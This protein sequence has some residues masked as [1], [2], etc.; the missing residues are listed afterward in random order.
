MKKQILTFLL[1]IL[2]I[3]GLRSQTINFEENT[4]HGLQGKFQGSLDSD[5]NVLISTGFTEF[6]VDSQAWSTE[7][8]SFSSGVATPLS[9]DDLIDVHSGFGLVGELGGTSGKD[10]VVVGSTSITDNFCPEGR[11]YISNSSGGYDVQ[12]IEGLHQSQGGLADF[13]GDGD[14]DV[15]TQG[16]NSSGQRIIIVYLNN[17]GNFVQGWVADDPGKANGS[18]AIGNVGGDSKPDVLSSGQI[19]NTQTSTDTY[20][21]TS[22]VGNLSF[23][24][25][26]SN[27]F[28]NTLRGAN[29][30]ADL[31]GDG[32]I[33][34]I[35]QG[36]TVTE[37]S[38]EVYT[39]DGNNN[40]TS[41]GAVTGKWLV[42]SGFD[43]VDGDGDQDFY[44]QG[45]EIDAS[46]TFEL[47]LND[48]SGN[49]TLETSS[50][51]P[52]GRVDGPF[53]LMD[54]DQDGDMDPISMG[55]LNDPPFATGLVRVF[56]NN[57]SSCT[58]ITVYEDLDGDTFGDPNVSLE[59]CSDDIPSGFV[60]DG[61]D[62][63]PT[64][65]NTDQLNTDGDTEGDACD[66]D[67]DNDGNPDTT[68][69]NPLFATTAPDLL[70]ITSLDGNTVNILNNDDF[71]GSS[72]TSL[73]MTAGTADSSRVI[74]DPIT[75]N[76]TY[77]PIEME[78]GQTLTV[79]YEVCYLPTGVCGTN[80]VTLQ[81]DNVLSI[82]DIIINN[83]I[84]LYPN[85]TSG[86]VRIETPSAIS[87]QQLSVINMQ[88]QV[89]LA[90][91]NQS[92]L[93]LSS[94]PSG[95]YIAQIE[96]NAGI[97]EKLLV[98]D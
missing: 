57:S 3:A 28:P 80:T 8:Y 48:G 34:T 32:E 12:V 72:N 16:A 91:S 46:Q 11:I 88:G 42:S 83:E 45:R 1:F 37:L 39:G 23:T 67:D 54:I 21:N 27:P 19:S 66:D 90:Y 68:D 51:L 64:I 61:T 56:F 75:G 69:P 78:A 43:D 49:F 4:I 30:L 7:V 79:V 38:G 2:S 94:L 36:A 81:I 73:F 77:T 13:D 53:H 44:S 15:W 76:M 82:K 41:F 65:A 52:G 74:F 10:Y 59:V 92:F 24:R 31:D 60:L 96:T 47:Y 9:I 87:I 55:T 84:Q 22:T 58:M 26:T 86:E 14:L 5:G 35:V 93:D 70:D 6:S 29:P 25:T 63:C 89:V 40:F 33:D 20:I 71:L 98:R 62:N 95:V 97:V 18:V 50:P 85:P 17:S